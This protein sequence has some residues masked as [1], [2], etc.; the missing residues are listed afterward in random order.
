MFMD[1]MLLA[2]GLVLIVKG[3]DWFVSASVRI[4]RFFH[5]PRVVVGS[6]LVS[7]ATTSPE[8][9]VSIMA[10]VR[11]ESAL[12]AGN[13]VGSV[14]CN[15]GLILG[16]TALFK[17]VQVRP[18]TLRLPLLAMLGLGMLLFAMSLDQRISR[19]QGLVLLLLGVAYYAADLT[20]ALRDRKARNVLEAAAIEQDLLSGRLFLESRTGSALQFAAGAFVVIAGSRL[21]VEGAVNVADALG[22]PS[23]IVGLTVIALGTS[24][25]ELVT[26][27][28]SI[29]QNVSDLAVGNILGANIANL[30]LVVGVAALLDEV[31]IDRATQWVNFPAMLLLMGILA[32]MLRSEA[33]LSRREGVWLVSLYLLY[34]FI[35]AVTALRT[36]A[37]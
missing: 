33:G 21:L 16:A 3:G 25:P 31:P 1:W 14:I 23:I 7:L 19:G 27:L 18:Q 24:L 5:L 8:L 29:R 20:R 30:S 26:A 28:I 12:A 37:A 35:V 15:I 6:T 17:R 34:L 9:A 10:G 36:A 22:I 13:A 11:G 2:G 32:W 4:A